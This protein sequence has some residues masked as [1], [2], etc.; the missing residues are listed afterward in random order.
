MQKDEAYTRYV[1]NLYDTQ[2]AKREVRLCVLK[3][4]VIIYIILT[5]EPMARLMLFSGVLYQGYISV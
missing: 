4:H 1:R 3:L 5:I 2:E